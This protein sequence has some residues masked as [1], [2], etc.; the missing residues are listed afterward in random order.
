MSAKTLTPAK[1]ALTRKEAAA[2]Y[3]VSVWTVDELIAAGTVA[4][5]KKGR[6]VLVDAESMRAWFDGLDDA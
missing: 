5:K 1:V 6:R 3:G 4:A 2:T